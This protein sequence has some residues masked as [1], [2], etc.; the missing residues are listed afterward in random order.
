MFVIIRRMPEALDRATLWTRMRF[1]LES[2][3][4]RLEGEQFVVECLD[5]LND[6]MDAELGVACVRFTDAKWSAIA[7][8]RQHRDVPTKGLGERRAKELERSIRGGRCIVGV[9]DCAGREFQHTQTI[10][11]VPMRRGMWR[12]AGGGTKTIGGIYLEI[13]T[14]L[15]KIDPLYLEFI[16]SASVLLSVTLDQRA[17]LEAAQE[18]LRAARAHDNIDEGPSLAGIMAAKSMEG[19]RSEIQACVVGESSVMILGES[20]TGKTRLA[21]AVAKASARTPIVRATLGA[22]DDLNTITSELFGHERG[23]FSGAVTRRKGLVEYADGGTLILDEILNLPPHAQQLLLDFSQFGT[24]RP[25]GYQGQEP[26]SANVRVISATNGNIGQAIADTRFRQ[27]LYFRLAGVIINLPPLRQRRSEIPDLAQRYLDRLD[28]AHSWRLSVPARRSL[29]SD[30]WEW[31]GNIRQLQAVIRSARDRAVAEG[32]ENETI[33]V[34][35]IGPPPR[36]MRIARVRT[37]SESRREP[38]APA[39]V[40]GVADVTEITED[41]AVEDRWQY[42]QAR[43]SSLDDLER[44]LIDR[45]LRENRG[46]VAHAARQLQVSRTSLLSRMATLRLD[47]KK[48]KRR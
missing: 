20:G 45:A 12:G 32:V 46:V 1:L 33:E 7:A 43:R 44:E 18:D 6:L 10:I 24:Y 34:S 26:K 29:L 36:V 16:D 30:S 42:L 48:Y 37:R 27:D 17:R 47:R 39:G 3:G 40:T 31:E 35:H 5:L 38:A 2:L 8:R 11:A 21:V 4:S 13:P 23:S 19:L 25:L 15:N 22:S 14:P 9:E 28:P 41:A